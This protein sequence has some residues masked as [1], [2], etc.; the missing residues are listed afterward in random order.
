MLQTEKVGK[1]GPYEEEEVVPDDYEPLCSQL[2][3]IVYIRLKN[4]KC[5][6]IQGFS[7]VTSMLLDRIEKLEKN[8]T[9]I[10]NILNKLIK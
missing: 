10:L 2:G 4:V 9:E 7:E 1:I 6:D 3:E 8:Q 5:R